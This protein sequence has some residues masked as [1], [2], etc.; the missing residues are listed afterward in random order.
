MIPDSMFC[1]GFPN[2]IIINKL[3]RKQKKIKHKQVVDTS[4]IH[5]LTVGHRLRNPTDQECQ[6]NGN[7]RTTR[8]MIEE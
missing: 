1:N 5:V 4:H 6:A 3:I 2:S 8:K 7:D